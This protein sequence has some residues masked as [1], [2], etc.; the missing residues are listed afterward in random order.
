VLKGELICVMCEVTKLTEGSKRQVQVGRLQAC[1][2]GQ[3]KREL[4]DKKPK[5]CQAISSRIL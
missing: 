1:R 3:V 2:V 5:T 4:N